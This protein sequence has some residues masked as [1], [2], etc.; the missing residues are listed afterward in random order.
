M[1]LFF[2]FCHEVCS[3]DLYMVYEH[4][5]FGVKIFVHALFLLDFFPVEVDTKR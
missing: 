4:P 2:I 3:L 5:G 1:K